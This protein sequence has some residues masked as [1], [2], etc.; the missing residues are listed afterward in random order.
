MFTPLTKS[1]QMLCHLNRA[2]ALYPIALSLRPS[3]YS[4]VVACGPVRY[5]YKTYEG[6]ESPQSIIPLT[7]VSHSFLITL[8]IY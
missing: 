4:S 5:V 2:L 3:Y 6:L 1:G 8:F 7:E